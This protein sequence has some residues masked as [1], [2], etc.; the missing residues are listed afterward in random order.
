MAT[1]VGIKH[2][3]LPQPHTRAPT[4]S[5]WHQ[6]NLWVPITYNYHGQHVP[7]T[8]SHTPVGANHIQLRP[9]HAWHRTTTQLQHHQTRSTNH[10]QLAKATHVGSKHLQLPPPLG[11]HHIHLPS[12]Q[13]H[14]TATARHV[15]A[16]SPPSAT[17][18]HAGTNH[19]QLAP[20][21]TWTPTTSNCH[22]HARG[23]Q[24]RPSAIA[25]HT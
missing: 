5:N 1:H 3:Q 8:L 21:N 2:I 13:P 20:P 14:P 18:T 9:P 4:T 15:G 23:R 17:A 6:P 16:Q 11:T 25:P 22:R 24:P 19:I 12:Q 10:I 7:N